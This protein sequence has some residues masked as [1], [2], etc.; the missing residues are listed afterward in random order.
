VTS[1]PIRSTRGWDGAIA[2]IHAARSWGDFFFAMSCE[3][4]HLG[5]LFAGKRAL[6]PREKKSPGGLSLAGA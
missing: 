5:A 3:D 2:P 6:N 1:L 4:A